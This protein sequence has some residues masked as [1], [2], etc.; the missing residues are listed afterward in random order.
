VQSKVRVYRLTADDHIRGAI[1]RC[2][3]ALASAQD[4]ASA[5]RWNRCVSDLYFAVF[6]AADAALVRRGVYTKKHTQTQSEF[7]KVFVRTG[8]V[9]VETGRVYNRLFELRLEMDYQVTIT[10]EEADVSPLVEPT[11]GLV[12]CLV[13]LATE[14]TRK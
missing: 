13:T 9:E 5:G 3:E 6:Y 4:N 12:E 2:G 11:S 7:N 8:L 1:A 10:A 14:V